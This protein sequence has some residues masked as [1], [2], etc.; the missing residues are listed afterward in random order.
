MAQK[1]DIAVMGAGPG[2]YVA[3]LEAARL[4]ARVALIEKDR[5]G[6]TCLNRGCIPSKA[7]LAA[8]ELLHDIRH[9]TADMGIGA[10][11]PTFDWSAA[12]KRKNGIVRKQT[13]GLEFLFKKREIA[14]F[15]GTAVLEGPG[16]I[17]VQR[18]G[19]AD[20]I[21][22]EKVI[23]ATGSRPTRIPGW[24][25][26]E[27]V[28]TS[29]EALDWTEL[30][31][32]LLVVGGGVIGCEFACMMAEFGV[33]VTVVE[34]M[35]RLVPPMD[36]ALAV[37]LLKVFKS[38]GIVC[39]LATKVEEL[40]EQGGAVTA[41]LSGGKSVE[42][43]RVLVSIGR[44]ANVEGIG[45]EEAGIRVERGLVVVND[46][47]ETT[48][49]NHYA[50]GDVNGR[51]P[52]AHSASAMGKLA[53]EN[54]L[55]GAGR[56]FDAPSPW[57]VYTF[58]EIGGVGISEDQASER[59]IPVTVG[60]FPFAA[61]GKA[62]AFGDATGFVKTI[63]HRETDRILGVHAIGHGATEFIAAAGVL[64]HSEATAADVAEMIFAHPTM[65]EAVGESVEA[66][67][68]ACLHLPPTKV[69]S[70]SV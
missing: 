2:G 39:H 3:A 70:L 28:V 62:Q 27:A 34:M 21:E 59:G 12:L 41:T 67:L 60:S 50:I 54:A 9:R 68:F 24:P 36:S 31:K 44:R 32:R 52:L 46:L 56:S 6:G 53:A 49:A 15:E 38:R 30:P 57:C 25:E 51:V 63:R 11:E 42:V 14:T 69:A 17:A 23:V 7:Y 22:A 4:G 10:A 13:Q 65:S 19:E 55:E 58:P 40:V 18:D 66:S 37:A 8:A 20:E 33:E 64:V 16:R 35:P 26:S 48:L 61:S 43:D 45:L 29:D 5:P 47:M 1:F